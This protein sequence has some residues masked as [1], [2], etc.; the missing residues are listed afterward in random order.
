[1]APPGHEGEPAVVAAEDLVGDLRADDDGPVDTDETIL[2]TAA[3][4][5]WVVA[6][7]QDDRTTV[8]TD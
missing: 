1:M 5:G 6:S 2:E 4:L 7:I 8:V 3:R